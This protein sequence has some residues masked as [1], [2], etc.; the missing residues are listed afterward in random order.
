MKHHFIHMSR[1][2][3]VHSSGHPFI[4][5]WSVYSNRAEKEWNIDVARWRKQSPIIISGEALQDMAPLLLIA[6]MRKKTCENI[7]LWQNV[8]SGTKLVS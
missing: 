1:H 4:P 8:C 7:H 3:S 5:S 2:P 6:T